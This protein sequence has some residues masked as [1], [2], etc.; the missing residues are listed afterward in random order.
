MDINAPSITVKDAQISVIDM[1]GQSI[2]T[3]PVTLHTGANKEMISMTVAASGVYIVQLTV[4]GQ[5]L[6]YRLVLDKQ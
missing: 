1:V 5:S 4:D 2:V 3:R 6:Y